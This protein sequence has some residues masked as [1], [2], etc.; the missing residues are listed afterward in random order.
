MVMGTAAA[1]GLDDFAE[2]LRLWR[3]RQNCTQ[4]EAA[5]LLHI[6]RSYLSHVERGR[7]PGRALRERC[8]PLEKAASLKLPKTKVGKPSSLRNLPI[9]SWAQA[10]QA[11][12]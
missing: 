1:P 8:L 3:A 6:T 12:D 7:P 2:R 4:A 5:R 10:G 9:L 11:T